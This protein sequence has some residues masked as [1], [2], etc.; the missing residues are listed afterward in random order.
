MFP[1]ISQLLMISDESVQSEGIKALVTVCK[2]KILNL[3][4]T[5]FLVHNVL[6]ILF[7]KASV[8]ENSKVGAL[9]L[10]DA[11]VSEDFFGK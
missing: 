11:F 4:D 2:E 10:L 9:L 1:L 7:K 6:Q 3:E 5:V 8:S